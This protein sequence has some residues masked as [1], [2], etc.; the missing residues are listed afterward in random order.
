MQIHCQQVF[1]KEKSDYTVKNIMPISTANFSS[2]I[3]TFCKFDEKHDTHEDY[4]HL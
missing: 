3:S 2:N 4:V 1:P